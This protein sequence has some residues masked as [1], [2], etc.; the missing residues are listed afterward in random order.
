M[1][2]VIDGLGYGGAERSL[3]ELLPGLVADGIE[4]TVACLFHREGGVE[5]EVLGRGHDVRFLPRG[6]IARIRALRRLV[7]EVSPDLIQTTLIASTMVGRLAG[8]GTRIPVMTS[9]VNQPYSPER[10]ADPH[11][12]ALAL[13]A[14][15][16]AD[17]WTA[18]HLTTHFHAITHAV[19]RAA[20]RDLRIPEDR[21]TVIERG[22][23]PERLGEPSPE[24]RAGAREMLGLA[25]DAEVILAVGRQE[26]QKGHRFLFE[27][28][29]TIAASR[30]RAVLLLA[31][32]GGAE[33]DH[34][35]R[36]AEHPP[37]DRI[38]RFLGHR[39]DLPEILAAADVFAF[40]S[41][42]EG[43]GCAV[44]E[45]MALGLPIVASDLE[46]VREV[47]E[48]GRCAV[49]VPAST[50][51]ALASAISSVLDDPV[52]AQTLAHTGREIFLRRFT[53][54]RSTERMVE[55]CHRVAGHAS[56]VAPVPRGGAMAPRVGGTGAMPSSGENEVA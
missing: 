36:M 37:L 47:V 14:V 12:N 26:F 44:L 7:R 22:R 8:V 2:C 34:L 41:L 15:R 13:R 40:P 10:R 27:A 25:P 29:T 38:V 5:D 49:L 17:G 52:R 42:W 56:R 48:D 31:G 32:R 24:R 45:A 16:A 46:P 18:R 50:P 11:V 4:P 55:L 28:M 35:Q 9:L 20:V 54:E 1:L 3:A 43:L 51:A 33:A 39:Q 53:L 21:I 6:R 23:D 30:P 19:K